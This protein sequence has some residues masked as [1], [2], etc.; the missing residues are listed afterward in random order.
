MFYAQQIVYNGTCEN[1]IRNTLYW[2]FDNKEQRDQ[3]VLCGINVYTEKAS[4]VKDK[5]K[6]KKFNHFTKS[7]SGLFLLLN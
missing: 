3:A 2:A 5:A 4:N 7:F 6:V 1:P